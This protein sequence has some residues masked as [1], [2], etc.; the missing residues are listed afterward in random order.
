MGAGDALLAGC[1]AAGDVDPAQA[2][3]MAVAWGA[4]AVAHPGSRMPT[5][6]DIDLAAVEVREEPLPAGIPAVA[7][8]AG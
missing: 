2:L 1:L 8:R 5:P 7:A 4:A 3:R 6:E